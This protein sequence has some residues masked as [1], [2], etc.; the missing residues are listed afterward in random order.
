MITGKLEMFTFPAKGLFEI[1]LLVIYK[2]VDLQNIKHQV[3]TWFYITGAP[4]DVH[5]AYGVSKN[6]GRRIQ[7][8]FEHL[9][10]STLRLL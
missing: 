9:R 4:A 8:V 2:I 7:D 5:A 1:I 10:K 3:S 6:A